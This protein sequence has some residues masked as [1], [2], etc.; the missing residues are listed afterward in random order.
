[1]DRRDAFAPCCTMRVVDGL[2]EPCLAVVVPCFN[3]APTLELASPRSW[4]SRTRPEYDRA[5]YGALL[6]SSAAWG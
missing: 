1:M 6:S 4:S 2:V 5:D 3:E